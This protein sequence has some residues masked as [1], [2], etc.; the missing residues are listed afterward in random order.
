MGS[1]F[2]GENRG[3]PSTKDAEDSTFAEARGQ[4][5]MMV[6]RRDRGIVRAL[7]Q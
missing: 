7:G 1:D 3:F 5:W 4:N 2:Q 6:N